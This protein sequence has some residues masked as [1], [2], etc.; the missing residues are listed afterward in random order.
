MPSFGDFL[1]YIEPDP[2]F[3]HHIIPNQDIELPSSQTRMIPKKERSWMDFVQDPTYKTREYFHNKQDDQYGPSDTT[4][5]T[6]ALGLFSQSYGPE[7]AAPSHLPGLGGAEHLMEAASPI[8]ARAEL[9]DRAKALATRTASDFNAAGAPKLADVT[10]TMFKKHPNIVGNF[11][12]TELAPST[13][14]DAP[15]STKAAFAS[16][17]E[18]D[19]K[20]IRSLIYDPDSLRN[21]PHPVVREGARLIKTLPEWERVDM[22]T[23]SPIMPRLKVNLAMEHQPTD[24]I[25]E[26]VRHEFS[27][28]GDFIYRPTKEGTFYPAGDPRYWQSRPEIRA[29]ATSKNWQ[30]DLGNTKANLLPSGGREKFSDKVFNEMI[31]GSDQAKKQMIQNEIDKMGLP[32]GTRVPP[33]TPEQIASIQRTARISGTE[34]EDVWNHFFKGGRRISGNQM[35]IRPP[36]LSLPSGGSFEDILAELSR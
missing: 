24:E 10:E 21:H 22:L 3:G 31:Y 35:I 30:R 28:A 29:R 34:A 32:P 14:L 16:L 20:T 12:N 6:D 8:V 15:G 18:F 13:P 2:E 25:A 7:G 26:T 27:H 4:L 33:P 19:A 23:A 17:N 5:P 1:S 9:K 11:G 36:R